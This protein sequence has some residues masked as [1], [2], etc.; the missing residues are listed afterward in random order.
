MRYGTFDPEKREYRIDRVD[1]PVSWTN[2]IGV[3]EMCAVVNHTAGG[4]LFYNDYC[5][6]AFVPCVKDA[7]AIVRNAVTK[8]E[9]K[10]RGRKPIE[11]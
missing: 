7:P 9:P 2:Y 4:Y 5:G 3:E 11:K 8:D 10:P 6:I 1:L